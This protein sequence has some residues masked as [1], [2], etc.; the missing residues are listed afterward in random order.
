M[1]F[2]VTFYCYVPVEMQLKIVIAIFDRWGIYIILSH[3]AWVIICAC[4][5][6][7]TVHPDNGQECT[8]LLML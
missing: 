5:Y 7:L 2:A 1:T 4:G 6:L 8:L 3:P